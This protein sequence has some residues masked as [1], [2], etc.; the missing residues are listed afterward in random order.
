[1]EAT[2][3]SADDELGS[4]FSPFL[5]LS[6]LLLAAAAAAALK[7]ATSL[8]VVEDKDESGG[9]KSS[10]SGAADASLIILSSSS[11]FSVAR[12][13]DVGVIAAVDLIVGVH[14]C[15]GRTGCTRCLTS[16]RLLVVEKPSTRKGH[17][18]PISSI[19]RQAIAVNIKDGWH[20]RFISA[21]YLLVEHL[22]CFPLC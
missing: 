7:D 6:F 18:K 9:D 8:K 4:S 1:L 5:S 10:L 17:T 11:K 22:Y 15:R 13:R 20:K 21:L 2:D 19:R 3:L 12:S 14:G 16:R